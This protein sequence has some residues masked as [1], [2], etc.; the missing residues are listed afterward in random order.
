M[1][2]M[3]ERVVVSRRVDNRADGRAGAGVKT[4]SATAIAAE[5]MHGH[6]HRGFTEAATTTL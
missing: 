4:S 5:I 3:R 2:G 1:L 6:G